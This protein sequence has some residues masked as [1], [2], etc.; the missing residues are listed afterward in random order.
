MNKTTNDYLCDVRK[1]YFN[2]LCKIARNNENIVVLDADSREPT[3][4]YIFSNEFPDRSFNFGICEQNM[5]SAAAGMATE[6][7]VP[8]VNT[9]A[10][11]I[12]YRAL[13][14]VRN[15]IAY[16]NLNVKIAVSHFGLDVGPD[17]VTHQTIED[18]SIIRSIPNMT[19]L[20]PAD[21]IEASQ[22]VDFICDTNGP[23]YTKTGKSKV[24]R[25]H[26]EDYKFK[27]GEP[28][29]LI[30]GNDIAIFSW[31]LMLE[32]ALK[33]AKILIDEGINASVVNISTLK[34]LN[35]RSV[36]EILKNSGSAVIVEDH[37]VFGGLGSIISEISSK[38]LPVP[39]EFVGVNDEFSEGG[40]SDLLYQKHNMT[41]EE[42]IKKTNKCIKRKNS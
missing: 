41:I 40:D 15:S 32:R 20:A 23:V 37:N 5:V 11:F 35:E 13:D 31:G 38:H 18:I 34:P 10:A 27:F 21:D 28:D 42:I 1:A 39:I 2:Q 12:S 24:R 8:F 17:G 36:F 6:G 29:I 30:D 7:L 22:M 25:I 26:S 9:F 4:S 33:A 14:Q 3:N 19:L 16:P